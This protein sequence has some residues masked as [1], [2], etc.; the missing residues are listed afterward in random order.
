MTKWER[1]TDAHLE[2][3][4]FYCVCVSWAGGARDPYFFILLLFIYLLAAAH[5]LQDLSSLTRD[6]THAP[7]SGRAESF[8]FFFLATLHSIGNFPDQGWNPCPLPWKHR[9]LTTGPPGKSLEEHIFACKYRDLKHFLHLKIDLL[10]KENLS[11][12]T[13]FACRQHDREKI[14]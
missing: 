6:Q 11:S 2:E 4:I 14:P 13:L 5:S 3:R 9:I 8:F 1:T 10:T 12:F 7:C